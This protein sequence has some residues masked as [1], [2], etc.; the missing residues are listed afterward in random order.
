MAPK[1]GKNERR[2]VEAAARAELDGDELSEEQ[3]AAMLRKGM[4]IDAGGLQKGEE[5]LF[6]KKM[7]K[8]EKKAAMEVGAAGTRRAEVARE[9]RVRHTDAGVLC[10]RRRRRLR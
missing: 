6:D 4:G 9:E 10:R 2:R 5:K 1:L 7:S 3:R 8:E